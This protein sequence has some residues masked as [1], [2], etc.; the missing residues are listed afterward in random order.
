LRGKHLYLNRHFVSF[1]NPEELPY[2]SVRIDPDSFR[3]G[4][5]FHE[6]PGDAGV[7]R[8]RYQNNSKKVADP[9]LVLDVSKLISAYE[10][11]AT[12]ASATPDDLG[13]FSLQYSSQE[14]LWVA[15]LP[16][17]WA[18]TFTRKR[19]PSWPDQAV[20]AMCF[21]RG[22][23]VLGVLESPFRKYMEQRR[24]QSSF[25]T[26]CRYTVIADDS[27]RR[28]TVK[29]W[30]RFYRRKQDGLLPNQSGAGLKWAGKCRSEWEILKD[31]GWSDGA[32]DSL[33]EEDC[34]E[35]GVDLDQIY[36][37][38]NPRIDD[39]YSA[40]LSAMRSQLTAVEIQ[41]AEESHVQ[42]RANNPIW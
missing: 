13:A 33:I 8:A 1:A 9:G 41:E 31:H 42:E 24:V 22:E 15:C 20:G 29:W 30:R 34:K 25:W 10:W 36:S 11:I 39:G 32:I 18:E 4:I 3:I 12:V 21:L 17:P 23:V 38:K 6:D 35:I 26:A 27:R 37:I 7:Y 2:V 16:L 5:V 19:Q 14:K 40:A 28:S